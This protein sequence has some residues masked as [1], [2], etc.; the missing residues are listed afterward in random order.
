MYLEVNIDIGKDAGGTPKVQAGPNDIGGTTADR[1]A[2]RLGHTLVREVQVE[3]GGQ[4]IDTH[5]GE[6]L[7]LWSQLTLTSETLG[8]LRSLVDGNIRDT[9]PELVDAANGQRKDKSG[10]KR[11]LYIPLQFWFN[12]NPGLALP[13][14]ALQYHEVKINVFLEDRHNVGF[15]TGGSTDGSLGN[16]VFDPG[17]ANILLYCSCSIRYS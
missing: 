6:W 12:R 16:F 17:T 5:Y 8:G 10:N 13:L 9:S 4:C 2:Q 11:K 15:A 14:I 1:F 3:I 7:E